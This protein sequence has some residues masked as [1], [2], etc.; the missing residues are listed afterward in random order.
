MK[1][2]E[3][4]KK[5][6]F[7]ISPTYFGEFFAIRSRQVAQKVER[8]EGLSDLSQY[9]TENYGRKVK[10]GPFEGLMLPKAMEHRH[11]GPFLF[12][13]YESTLHEVIN[14]LKDKK[15]EVVVDIGSSFGYYAV[16]LAN[17]F[18]ESPVY[19]FD[20]DPW[21][22]EQ[23]KKMAALNGSNNLNVYSV[24]TPSI[25]KKIVKGSGLIFSDCEGYESE[26]FNQDV[27]KH[28][29]D[30]DLIIEIHPGGS[31]EVLEKLQDRFKLTH[32]SYV[33]DME[34]ESNKN[35]FLPKEIDSDA[36]NEWRSDGQ[37]WLV[38]FHCAY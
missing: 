2:K 22:R 19:A 10:A 15:Y 33:Y 18:N 3:L 29:R 24:C 23:V 27:I 8:R 25:L 31:Q 16:G 1:F 30:S 5:T 14:S 6:L 35:R 20:T 32:N 11:I 34:S 4:V 38:C 12:G 36:I 26:L 9:L 28:L 21:A 7:K 13:S 17:L 37:Q